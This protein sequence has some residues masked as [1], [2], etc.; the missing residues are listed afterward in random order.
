VTE[1]AGTAAARSFGD[2]ELVE[3]IA[4]GGMG[5]V[6]RAVQKKLNRTV[7]LK[8]IVA[9]QLASEEAVRRFHAEAEAAAQLDHPGIVPIFEVGEQEGQHFFS[10]GLVEGGS[11]AGRLRD[12]G[13]LPPAEAAR[14][15]QKI[16]LAVA[17]AHGKGIVHRDLKPANVL[18]DRDGQPRVTD[19]GLAKRLEGEAGLTGTGQVMGTPGYMPPEQARSDKDVGPAA[20]VYALGAI[21]YCL[22]TGRPPFQ[23]AGVMETLRQVLEQEPVSPRQLNAAVGRD[24]ETIC[25]KCLQKEPAGRYNGARAL[26][27][28]LGRF[29]AG[30]PILARPISAW[31]RGWRWV[32]RRPATAGLGLMSGV[33][34]LALALAA[35]GGF[36]NTQ[37]ENAYLAEAEM[38]RQADTA[39]EGEEHQRKEAETARGKMEQ[40]LDLADRS[41]YINR[42]LLANVALGESD[43]K[44]AEVLLAACEPRQRDWEWFYLNN[45]C[46]PGLL[47]LPNAARVA[48]SPVGHLASESGK[49]WDVRTG[50]EVFNLQAALQAVAF[51]PDGHLVSAGGDGNVRIRDLANGW[52]VLTFRWSSAKPGGR[53]G[54]QGDFSMAVSPDGRCIAIVTEEL[55]PGPRA[56]MMVR[57]WDARTGQETLRLKA[58]GLNGI[59]FSPDGKLLACGFGE[60][61][62]AGSRDPFDL[63]LWDAVTGRPALTLKGH[64]APIRGVAFSPDG[65]RLATASWDRTVRVW[66]LHTGRE[67]LKLT[68]H[69]QEVQCVAYRPDGQVLAS[70][71][72]DRRVR[73]WDAQ[74]GV[75]LFTLGGHDVGIRSVVFS[76]DSRRLASVD[77][78]GAVRVWDADAKEPRIARMTGRG[79]AFSPDSR[80][81]VEGG[82]WWT[83]NGGFLQS[84]V[85]VWDVDKGQEIRTLPRSYPGVRLQDSGS[86]ALAFGPDGIHVA[87]SGPNNTAD[88]WDVTSGQRCLTL[89][90]HKGR[91]SDVAFS[92]DG[93]RLAT[94]SWDRTVR[95]WDTRAG[96]DLQR[97]TG[98]GNQVLGVAFSPDGRRLATASADGTVR[99]WQ[100]DTGQELLRMRGPAYFCV[101]YSPDGRYLAAGGVRGEMRAWDAVSGQEVVS[102]KGHTTTV[103]GIAFG[104]G[105]RRVASGAEDGMVKLWDVASGQEILSLQGPSA[106]VE[107]LAFSADGRYLASSSGSGIGIWDAA[108]STAQAQAMRRAYLES[109]Q[110]S[111]R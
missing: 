77:R 72:N 75:E 38:R 41:V 90:G 3:P 29:L 47:A 35:V 80:R 8:M 4:R 69:T 109:R 99:V 45:L 98:H 76:P 92:P 43:L 61:M 1:S 5:V 83:A 111:G 46:S 66:D 12:A 105:G 97:L 108:R 27:D 71:G 64:T 10:M 58:P 82:Q 68:G 81:L 67:L 9:G 33:A 65:S 57:V 52:E 62:I 88:I 106:H 53:I 107:R 30:E 44:R 51:G 37:L 16:A 7:A 21:L 54:W 20:D 91:V 42:I 84:P 32:K 24:L 96:Q 89:E 18:L 22:L 31:E 26:A 6:Y 25:L 14:L 101:A 13:P 85:K 95:I 49:I 19:F 100:A 56:Q 23:A 36:Y 78:M 70:G 86:A 17:Y 93:T 39:R 87:C 40:A 48:F 63:P 59:A 103:S 79:V 102:F 55:H 60:G 73:L 110:S 50:Q 28:D 34:I 104:P 15:V 94:A 11:L 74:A 2:Y